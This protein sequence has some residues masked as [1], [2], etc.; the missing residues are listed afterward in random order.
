[1]KLY[2][3]GEKV[4]SRKKI[5]DLIETIFKLRSQGATQWKTASSLGVERS[6]VSHLERLAEIRKGK[7]I[8]LIGFPIANKEEV[9]NIAIEYGVD[10]V[11]LLSEDE[12]NAYAR[13]KSGA[14]IFNEVLDMIAKLKEFDLIIFL[15]SDRRLE[16]MKEIFG[17][18]VYSVELGHSPLNEDKKVD[19][20]ELKDTLNNLARKRGG[21][22]IEK[23]R[24]YKSRIFKKK[25]RSRSRVSG[26]KV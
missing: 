20:E 17:R 23:S 19:I 2:R 25:P 16:T 24:Q 8:A 22:L 15:G 5:L 4:V 6:F 12:R 21:K 11:Y 14:E 13:Q 26:R 7:K 10:F 9:E 3:I 1:M 18:A